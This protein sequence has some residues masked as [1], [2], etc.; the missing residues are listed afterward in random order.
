[1]LEALIAATEDFGIA[2]RILDKN[3]DGRYLITS[4]CS[5]NTFCLSVCMVDENKLACAQGIEQKN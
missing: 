4:M 3:R 5:N 1:M 2:K